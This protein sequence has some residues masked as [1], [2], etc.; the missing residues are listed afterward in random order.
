MS[1]AIDTI[2]S[3]F[4][5]L[6]EIIVEI[7]SVNRS[8]GSS[9]VWYFSTSDRSDGGTEFYP[10]IQVGSILGPITQS[11]T[12]DA[13]FSAL[14]QIS[15]G[16]LTLTQKVVDV[17]QL[18]QMM[19]YV[20]A[21]QLVRVKLGRT[22]DQYGAFETWRAVTVSVDPSIKLT[23]DGLQAIFTLS[24]AYE[25]LLKEDLV[26]SHYVG[27]STCAE[28]LTTT[29]VATCSYNAVH[30]LLTFTIGCRF[31]ASSTPA[32]ARNL[33]AKTSGSTNNN[34]VINLLTSGFIECSVSI[35]GV[36]V[37]L[38]T[39]AVNLCDGNWHNIVWS[40]AD[41]TNS[42]LSIDKTLINET[43]PSGSVNLPNVGVRFARFIVG[44][45]SDVR[46][47]NRYITLD[48]SN[49]IFSVAT[50]G[51]D[52]GCVG[53]WKLDDGGSSTIGNDYSPSNLD[54]TWTG[55]LNTDYKWTYSDL[56]EP[57]LAGAL[58]PISLGNIYNT[59]A[60]TLDAFRKRYR[61]LSGFIDWG[62][63]TITLKSQGTPL[64]INTDFTTVTNEGIVVTTASEADP[65]TFDISRQEATPSNLYPS[66]VAYNLLTSYTTIQYSQI[67][68]YAPLWMLAPWNSGYHTDKETTAQEALSFILG[69]SGFYYT[70]SETGKL[71]FDCYLPPT[72]YGPYGD[73][74]FDLRG[75]LDG[76]VT[77]GNIGS[78]SGSCTIAGWVKINISDQTGLGG[79]MPNEGTQYFL[80]KSSTSG[81]YALYFQATGTSAGR[82]GFR[83]AG[84]T[85]ESAPG[86]ITPYKWYFLAATFDITAD[87]MKLYLGVQGGTLTEIASKA[88]TGTPTTNSNSLTIGG[89]S[90]YPWFGVQHLQVWNTSKTLSQIQT[91]MAAT[92]LVG[93][94]SGLVIY[95]PANEGTGSPREVVNNTTGT[96]GV[97]SSSEGYPQ[98]APK[99][100]VN[101]LDTPDIKLDDLH[102]INPVWSAIVNYAKNYSKLDNSDVDTGVSQNNRLR[103]TKE[104]QSIPFESQTIKGRFKRA[105]KIIVD[106]PLIDREQ[107]SR[108]LRAYVLRFGVNNLLGTLKFPPGLNASRLSCGLLLG[109]EI[110]VVTPIPGVPTALSTGLSF[111]IVAI[112]PNIL[113]LENT[114]TIAR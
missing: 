25:N 72:G 79:V 2:L 81:N 31:K 89:N 99:M 78:I 110:G 61:L 38:H 35:A 70:E 57:E 87:T 104:S 103:L 27:I 11:L 90:T 59:K 75:R 37:T 66:S 86:F 58:Y 40:L 36:A 26:A 108:L 84:V 65:I 15:A 44:K 41:K 67:A 34:F 14:A 88:N 62:F 63:T 101:L 100:V 93:N 7:D 23:S 74:C 6:L 50:D 76:K 97:F 49:G 10:Y 112:S 98:W 54:A 43:I 71:W 55:V 42:Y 21:G 46:L 102:Y 113:K 60:H 95:I 3:D 18:S 69:Q 17:D 109:D 28:V 48:E 45:H 20:F 24:S 47:Y 16:T 94:E 106:S 8:D 12:E 107:A 9:K 105:K 32:A 53:C 56:G 1:L 52:L 33:I 64:T 83:I 77:F 5:S 39:S 4:D 22:T 51:Q 114:I 80:S 19:N 111:R 29:A 91:L 82:L 73:P 68:N 85:L 13:L 30:D 92:S 96:I